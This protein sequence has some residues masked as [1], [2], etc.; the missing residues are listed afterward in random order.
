VAAV[1]ERSCDIFAT[2]SL[3][4]ACE[5]LAKPRRFR[6]N[7]KSVQFYVEVDPP[8]LSVFKDVQEAD[9]PT[10]GR[11]SWYEGDVET[12]YTFVLNAGHA[13]YKFVRGRGDNA[14]A[15]FYI[16][17]EMLR[18]AYLIAFSNGV[19]RGPAA[20]FEDVLSGEGH[21]ADEV[22]KAFLEVIGAAINEVRR[23]S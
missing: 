14:M 1:D 15:T 21:A 2:V 10:D 13:A 16:Q 8:G 9:Q 5:E 6:L 23:A 22:G 4:R 12:G 18:Q 17:E 3:A 19:Y 7:R 20:E 11:Q